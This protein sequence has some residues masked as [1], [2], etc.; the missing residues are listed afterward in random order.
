M[1]ASEIA[2]CVYCMT[3]FKPSEVAEWIDDE[4]A[5]ALCPYC[6]VDAVVG[7][8]GAVDATWIADERRKRFE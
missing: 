7:F 5:T 6:G 4:H 8:D 2:V 1:A 3:E